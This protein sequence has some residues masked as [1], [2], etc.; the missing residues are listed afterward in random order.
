MVK[1]VLR[2]CIN[3]GGLVSRVMSKI[4]ANISKNQT[5]ATKIALKITSVIN[6]M[7]KLYEII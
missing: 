2:T 4:V 6:H 1:F 7:K 5:L 3:L